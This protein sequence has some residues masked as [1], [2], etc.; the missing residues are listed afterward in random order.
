MEQEVRHGL[1]DGTFIPELMTFPVFSR[2]AVSG[3]FNHPH[4]RPWK[5]IDEYVVPGLASVLGTSQTTL[6]WFATLFIAN[7]SVAI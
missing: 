7:P 4:D 6:K 5:N 1:P 2:R 3:H